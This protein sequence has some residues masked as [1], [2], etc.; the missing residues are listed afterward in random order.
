MFTANLWQK[1]IEQMQFILSFWFSFP[2]DLFRIL[3]FVVLLALIML[4]FHLGS[5]VCGFTTAT[6][7][8]LQDNFTWIG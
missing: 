3:I 1:T 7:L 4:P 2:A 6:L 8:Y 5:I